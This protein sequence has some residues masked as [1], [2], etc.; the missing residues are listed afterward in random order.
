MAEKSE[1]VVLLNDI[2]AMR[3]RVH[4]LVSDHWDEDFMDMESK[5][6]DTV[7]YMMMKEEV[8]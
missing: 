8:E 7:L 3:K 4:D 6:V 5:L 1:Y 2:I